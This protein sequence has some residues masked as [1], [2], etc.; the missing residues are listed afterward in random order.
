MT[1][2]AANATTSATMYTTA[3]NPSPSADSDR[4][5][6]VVTSDWAMTGVVSVDNGLLS[7]RKDR[8]GYG[9]T[10]L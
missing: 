1:V 9:D 4:T 7:E 3:E 8:R 10:S 2:T 5:A 6:I